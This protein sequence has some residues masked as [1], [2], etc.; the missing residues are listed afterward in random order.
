MFT[1]RPSLPQKLGKLGAVCCIPII[2]SR[3]VT[4][5]GGEVFVEPNV[6]LAVPWWE[7]QGRLGTGM[8]ECS[9]RLGQCDRVT[10][11]GLHCQR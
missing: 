1:G 5:V 8:A 3:E 6:G 7:Q 2:F 10:V 9:D 11:Q 4:L